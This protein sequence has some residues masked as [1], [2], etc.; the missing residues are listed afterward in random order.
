ME[1]SYLNKIDSDKNYDE[2]GF[3]GKKILVCEDNVLN[4]KIISKMLK[5][6]C[7]VVDLAKNGREC[8]DKSKSE[9]YD[10]IITDI[11]MP[12]IDGITATKEI[13]KFNKNI[14]IIALSAES[15]SDNV[16]KAIN[17]GMDAYLLKPI[18]SDKMFNT[19]YE[20]GK[21]TF[22]AGNQCYY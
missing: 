4:I 18:N 11:K 22:N 21:K 2:A 19:I 8:I 7:I 20:L 17:A 14:P 6:N 1:P 3:K 13:R 5:N 10:F 12:G 9:K 15:D 16:Q